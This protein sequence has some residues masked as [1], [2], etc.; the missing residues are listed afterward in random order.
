MMASLPTCPPVTITKR[1]KLKT[2]A[3]LIDFDGL[4]WLVN[5]GR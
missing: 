4:T 5:L 3:Q 1:E 2:L